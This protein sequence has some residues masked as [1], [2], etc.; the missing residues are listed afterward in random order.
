MQFNRKSDDGTSRRNVLKTAAVG[1]GMM[2][3]LSLVSAFLNLQ[4]TQTLAA[5]SGPSDHKALVCVFLKGGNDSFNMLAPKGSEYLSYSEARGSSL[6]G[7]PTGDGI[8]IPEQGADSLLDIAGPSGRTFGVHPRLGDEVSNL[9]SAATGGNGIR[10][11]YNNGKLSFIANVGSLIEPTDYASY[12]ARSNLPVGLFSH[13]DLQRHWMSSVPQ[14]R[15]HLKGWGGKMADLLYSMNDPSSISMNI[16][17]S[18]VNKFQTGSTV[19]PYSIDTGSAGGATGVFNYSPNPANASN[20]R[21]RAFNVMRSGLLG[22]TYDDLLSKTLAQSHL[23]SMQSALDFNNAVSAVT[24]NTVF[25]TDSF[26]QRMKRV[27][28]VIGARE[29]G[30]GLGQRRQVFFVDLGSFD[31]HASL[32]TNHDNYMEILSNGLSSFYQATVE[33][34]VE[35]NVV[36]FTAS[37]FARTLSSNGSGSDHAWG[38]NHIVMGGEIAGGNIRGDY[39]TNLKTP[40]FNGSTI[41]LGRGRLI[42]TTS[43]DQYNAELATWF[44]VSNSDLAD[45]LPNLSNFSGLTPLSLFA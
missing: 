17:L 44:G 1:C 20:N 35:D 6:N 8:A 23:L 41:D 32:L 27:A 10:G 28:Q 15:S 7:V 29:S 3:N 45:V 13:S 34:G 26:S 38:G 12:Q 31:H 25:D 21:N 14:D 16:S 4:A 24:V 2:S 33:L 9:N 22:Q 39:P 19:N 43:V 40:T 36:T 37:D 5:G 42:P 30:T 18:G 11:L